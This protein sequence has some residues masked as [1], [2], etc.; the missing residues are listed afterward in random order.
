MNSRVGAALAIAV[1][2]LLLGTGL[3]SPALGQLSPGELATVHASLEGSG[4]CLECHRSGTG[5]TAE[6]CLECHEPLARR[7]GEGLG[8]HSQPGYENCERCHIEHHGRDFELIWWGDEGMDSFDHAVTGYR[9]AG[10]HQELECRAC[11]RASLIAEPAALE[12]FGKDLDRTFLGLETACESC[13]ADP[14]RGEFAP[15]ACTD[16]HDQHAWQPAPG[17]DHAG[18]DFALRGSHREVACDG[19]HKREPEAEVRD[20]ALE[21][22]CSS[23]HADPHAGRLGKACE[24]CHGED[25]WSAVRLDHFDHA[26]TAFPLL[27]LHADVTCDECHRDSRRDTQGRDTLRIVGFDRCESCHADP[28]AGQLRSRDDGGDC[29][30]CHDVNGFSPAHFDVA[31]HE[32]TAYPLAGAHRAVA[33]VE[34]HETV[35]EDPSRAAAG[36]AADLPVGTVRFRFADLSCSGCHEG[37]HDGTGESA[38]RAWNLPDPSCTHCHGVESWS[39]IA[40]DHTLTPFALEGPHGDPSCADCHADEATA[41]SL[42]RFDTASATCASCHQ[43]PH[44]EQ[45]ADTSCGACHSGSTWEAV[46]FDHDSTRYPL[47]GAHERATCES[48]H[49]LEESA[50]GAF[51]RYRPLAFAS[52]ADCHF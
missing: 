15:R 47:E 25:S 2:G 16:C 52:C 7:L 29:T 35:A 30:S 8:L 6:L 1:V 20:F 37:P 26:T 24:S 31:D 44:R 34:C 41:D 50:D 21:T 42:L 3:A 10:K 46:T 22:A 17:F 9:P 13:H 28:H 11:H 19:C 23:C 49:R 5:A 48:C 18:T 51:V 32:R 4:Q 38:L 39:D 12:R 14:H 33:C 27:G 43:D 36:P 45:F 40:F